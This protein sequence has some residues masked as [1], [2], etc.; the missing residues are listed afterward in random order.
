MKK[1][2]PMPSVM[3]TEPSPKEE[4]AYALDRAVEKAV[5]AHPKT[6]VLREAIK[7]RMVKA[8]GNDHEA[9]AGKRKRGK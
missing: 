1:K 9:P 8:S 3:Y 6:Q 2:T 5:L 7:Q 4:L